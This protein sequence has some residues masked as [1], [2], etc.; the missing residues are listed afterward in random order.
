M[1]LY[2]LL[3]FDEV[4]QDLREARD[5]YKQKK[6]G[7]EKRF[8]RDIQTVI[9]RL[10]KKPHHYEVRYKNIR[11]AYPDVFPYAIHFYI[12]ENQNRIVIIAITHQRRDPGFPQGR[13]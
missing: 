12:D 8:I 4:K 6:E 1:S 9:T 13:K 10:H 2:T 5:W 11:I 3:Y 7:L